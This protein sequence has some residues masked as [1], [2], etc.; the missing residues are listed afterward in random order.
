MRICFKL[1]IALFL[2]IMCGISHAEKLETFRLVTDASSLQEGDKVIIVN[3][4]A[5]AALST[6]CNSS[7]IDG[8]EISF[9]GDVVVPTENVQLFTLEGSSSGW[10]F[11][12]GSK[13]LCTSSTE[14]SLTS[15]E[16]KDDYS[17]SSINIKDTGEAIIGFKKKP[18][19]QIAYNFD[20]KVFKYYNVIP[21]NGEVFLYKY[22]GDAL[23]SLTLDGTTA[24]ADNNS[25]IAGELNKTID[26]IT[27]ARTFTADGGWYTLC[28]PFA[29]TA[30]DISEKFK[31]ADF[32]EFSSLE[33]NAQNDYILNFK[34][35]SATDAGKPYMVKPVESIENPVFENKEISAATPVTVV[36]SCSGGRSV[37]CSFVGIFDPTALGEGNIRFVGSQGTSL[38]KPNGDGEKLKGLRAY[39]VLPSDEALAKIG[40]DGSSTNGIYTIHA[41]DGSSK[42]I[43]YNING[44]YVGDSAKNLKKGIYIVNGKKQIIK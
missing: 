18:S 10:Y 12:M 34:K 15:K 35:V 6:T 5:K 22:T 29:L 19:Y 1:I 33:T 40:L 24:S 13:Y 4:A 20:N 44:L 28:L 16:S 42:R 32:Q 11:K 41:G 31:G 3:Q 21:N 7:S 36:Q 38:V 9:D 2:S 25:V 27:V 26:R 43:I 23:Y 39:V 37:T 17:K 14:K 8:T 30:E